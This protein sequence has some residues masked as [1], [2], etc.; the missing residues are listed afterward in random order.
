MDLSEVILAMRSHD[1]L[2]PLTTITRLIAESASG[3]NSSTLDCNTLNSDTLIV[4]TSISHPTAEVAHVRN[5]MGI[6]SEKG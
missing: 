3:K 1:M 4:T 2:I 5:P 6:K